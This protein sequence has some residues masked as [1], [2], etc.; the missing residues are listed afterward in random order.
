MSSFFLDTSALVKR[1]K[2]EVGTAWLQNLIDPSIGHQIILSEIS[3]AKV[4]A[5]L[6]AAHRAPNGISEDQRDRALDL[7]LRH[8]LEEYDLVA[9]SRIIIDRAVDLTQNQKLRGCDA[10]Q[11]ATALIINDMLVAAGLTPLTFVA[12]DND[13]LSAAQGEELST[14]NPNIRP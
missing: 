2:S 11:L 3:L 8:C 1:Y 5:A 10:V 9:V 4:A 6:A 7:F 12:A 13:L 14:E